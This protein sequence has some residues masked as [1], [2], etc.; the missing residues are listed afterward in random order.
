MNLTT[1]L[2]LW[3]LYPG[4]CATNL[5]FRS[6]LGTNISYEILK[7]STL[8][9]Q[10]FTICASF[11]ENEVNKRSF[12]TIYGELNKP[13]MT[14]SNWRGDNTIIMW[15]K[16]NTVFSE[17][18][19]FPLHWM[20]FWNHVCISADTE[21]GN[22][23][24]FL[25]EDPP[26]SIRATNMNQERPQNIQGKLYI[27]LSES[28]RGVPKQFHGQVANFNIF[29]VNE[30][31]SIR[32]IATNPCQHIGDIVNMTTMWDRV[33][34]VEETNEENWKICNKNLTYSVPI[35]TKMNWN[36]AF[37][38]CNKLGNGNITEANNDIDK[39]HIISLFNDINN[40]CDFV[41]TPLVDE[42]I[43]GE[44]KSSITGKLAS[45]LPWNEN[46]PNGGKRQNH[47]AINVEAKL[48]DDV[49]K[50]KNV[51]PVCDIFKTT[52]FFILGVCN[53]TY[54]G[55]FDSYGPKLYLILYA[56]FQVC[57]K[58]YKKGNRI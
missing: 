31:E 9:P 57:T 33:G 55:K 48:Y 22:I 32:N 17:V 41:W 40:S 36:T 10:I 26:I 50:S 58:N 14:L 38:V 47:V 1:L 15:L 52:D 34:V 13:W 2:I 16:I 18:G 7:T 27:G 6:A 19:D 56:R 8:L 29:S 30:S 4:N 12:F 45:F 20:N 37:R 23:S 42:E 11:K 21:S 53:D 5:L 49:T 28:E 43:E 25:N 46:E 51:C 35:P 24:I 54:F 39:N 3:L 44:F